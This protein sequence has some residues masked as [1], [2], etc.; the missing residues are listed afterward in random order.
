[1]VTVFSSGSGLW[2]VESLK[3]RSLRIKPL[4]IDAEGL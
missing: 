1:M 4:D 2:H 3:V